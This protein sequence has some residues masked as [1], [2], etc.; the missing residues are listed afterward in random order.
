MQQEPQ[1]LHQ[2]G[3]NSVLQRVKDPIIIAHVHD[4]F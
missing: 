3:L 2:D 4:I 1:C